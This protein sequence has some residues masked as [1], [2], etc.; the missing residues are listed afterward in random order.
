M[1]SQQKTRKQGRGVNEKSENKGAEWWHAVFL[2]WAYLHIL[3][4]PLEKMDD[5]DELHRV[6]LV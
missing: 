6:A 5:H 3:D 4:L 2:L 1:S